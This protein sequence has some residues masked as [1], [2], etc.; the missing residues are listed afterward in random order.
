MPSYKIEIP[1]QGE[2]NVDS[3]NELSDEQVYLAVRQQL[4]QEQAVPTPPAQQTKPPQ[5]PAGILRRAGDLAISGAQGVIG[6]PESLV[7]LADIPTLG[8]AGKAAEALG[9]D[10]KRA[11]DILQ[12]YKSPEQQ[13][14]EK[15]VQ[16]AEG[17]MG[18]IGAA[19][20][21]PMAVGNTIMQSIPS[22]IGGGAIAKGILGVGAKPLSYM[23]NPATGA[24]VTTTGAGTLATALPSSAAA[25]AAG[26]GEG[27]VSGG[28]TAEQIRQGTE[29]GYLTPEQAGI[30]AV[31]GAFTGALGILGGKA[32]QRLGVGD[33]D[34]LLAGG[35]GSQEKK[36]IIVAALK[37]ALT[38]SV[39]EELPQSMQEQVAQNVATGRPWDEGVAEAGAM[40]VLAAIPMGGG[41]A[42]V[43]QWSANQR[44]D[45]IDYR[46]GLAEKPEEL[47]KQS[48]EDMQIEKN[49]IPGIKTN[50][51]GED[52]AIE[53]IPDASGASTT[54]PVQPAGGTGTTGGTTGIVGT[55][56]DGAGL[57]TGQTDGGAGAVRAPLAER[58]IDEDISAVPARNLRA[59]LKQ[60][61]GPDYTDEIDSRS[62]DGWT[63]QLKLDIAEAKSRRDNPAHIETSASPFNASELEEAGEAT[64]TTSTVSKQK[65]EQEAPKQYFTEPTRPSQDAPLGDKYKY[66]HDLMRYYVEQGES[67]V[68]LTEEAKSLLGESFDKDKDSDYITRQWGLAEGDVRTARSYT[69]D[70]QDEGESV[71]VS[72]DNAAKIAEL[73]KNREINAEDEAI[74]ERIR[75][76]VAA[77]EEERGAAMD[78]EQR[79]IV[80]KSYPYPTSSEEIPRGN[81]SAS[82]ASYD[83]DREEPIDGVEPDLPAWDN[84]TPQDR[85]LYRLVNYKEGPDAA[86]K[87]VFDHRADV[88]GKGIT[89]LKDREPQS[90]YYS[91]N[92]ENAGEQHKIKFPHWD[93][94]SP[95]AKQAFTSGSQDIEGIHDAFGKV[96]D[97]L[98]KEGVDIRGITPLEKADL[99]LRRTEEETKKVAAKENLQDRRKAG[100]ATG[101]GESVTKSDASHKAISSVQRS[102]ENGDTKSATKKLDS[103][104][105]HELNDT[106]RANV[107]DAIAKGKLDTAINLLEEAKKTE[108]QI[109]LESGDI[110]TVLSLLAEK[111][112]GIKLSV[113]ENEGMGALDAELKTPFKKLTSGMYRLVAKSLLS[114]GIDA[115]IVTDPNNS[116]IQRL[117]RIG[118]YGLYNPTTNTIYI[119]PEGMDEATI[120]HEFVHAGTVKLINKFLTNPASLTVQQREALEH[121]QK[122]FDFTKKKLGKKYVNAFKDLYEFMGYA[123]TDINFQHALR[124]IQAPTLSKYTANRVLR[125]LWNEFTT[126]LAK[127][128]GIMKAGITKLQL[129]DEYYDL[130]AKDFFANS[131]DRELYTPVAFNDLTAAEQERQL[132]AVD[133]LSKAITTA[134]EHDILESVLSAIDNDNYDINTKKDLDKLNRLISKRVDAETKARAKEKAAK[135]A[136]RTEPGQVFKQADKLL[137]AERGYAGNALLETAEIF[138]RI[139]EAPEGGIEMA[140]L[141]AAKSGAKGTKTQASQAP[142]GRTEDEMIGQAENGTPNVPETLFFKDLKSFFTIAGWRHAITKFQNDRYALVL[143]QD[144][145]KRAKRLI[146]DTGDKFNNVY[147]YV[148]EAF[149]RSMFYK[150]EYLDKPFNDLN[151]A[152]KAFM[153]AAGIKETRSAIAQ[154]GLYATAKTEHERRVPKYWK[155]VALSNTK[156]APDPTNNGQQAPAATIRRNIFLKLAEATGAIPDATIKA[157]ITALEQITGVSVQGGKI[158]IAPSQFIDPMLGHTLDENLNDVPPKKDATG[159]AIASKFVADIQVDAYRVSHLTYSEAETLLNHFEN[160]LGPE[161]KA[162]LDK[163]HPAL[164]AYQQATVDLNKMGHYWTDMVDNYKKFYNFQYYVPLKGRLNN[165]LPGENEQYSAFELSNMPL[166]TE[167]RQSVAQ[168]FEGR[169]TESQ[170]PI[171]Q[172]IVDGTTAAA[173]AGRAG[174]TQA[175]LNAV[176]DGSISAAHKPIH[177]PFKDRLH[178][179]DNMIKALRNRGTVIHYNADG[180]M[181]LITISDKDRALLEA[182]RRPF[183]ESHPVWELANRFTGFMGQQHTRFN[184]AFGLKN[185]NRD[186]LANAYIAAAEG[187]FGV[188]ARSLTGAAYNIT[189]NFSK[190][191]KMVR[192]FHQSDVAKMRAMAAADKSGYSTDLLEYIEKGRVSYASTLSVQN[193]LIT[194]HKKLGANGI[195]EAKD[196]FIKLFDAWNDTFELTARVSM[197]AAMRDAMLKELPVADRNRPSMVDGVKLHAAGYAKSMANFEEIGRYGKEMGALFMYFRASATG[198]VRAIQAMSPALRSLSSDAALVRG[199]PVTIVGTEETRNPSSK[200]FNKKHLDAY[201]HYLKDFKASQGTSAITGAA[202]LGMGATMYL[203]AAGA[204]GDDDEGRNVVISD[205]MARWTRAARFDF[206]TVNGERLTFQ[207]PWGFG[208]GGI[209]A[210]GAQVAALGMSP[211]NSA[212]DIMNNIWNISLD[213]FLPLPFSRMPVSENPSAWVVDSFTPTALRPAVEFA[214]NRNSFGQEIYNNRRTR[215]NDAYT[216]GD[217]IPEV[218][219]D[220]A[221]EL[222]QITGYDVSPNALYFWANNYMDALARV[223][224]LAGNWYLL[225]ANKKDFD[226]KHD[227]VLLDGYISNQSRVDMREYVK[228]QAEIDKLRSTLTTMREKEP[229][230]YADYLSKNPMAEVRVAAFDKMNGGALNGIKHEANLIRNMDLIPK[231]KAAMLRDNKQMQNIIMKN[232][233]DSDK[234]LKDMED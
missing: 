17:F 24:A 64:P 61:L 59:H 43:N 51:T 198:A 12:E 41:A 191:M 56:V 178:L 15:N 189:R 49:K 213:S 185:F 219:K 128:Y 55:G 125:T 144:T 7:G 46:K 215:F 233:N 151:D 130:F 208:L 38:E 234:M 132:D 70:Q 10:F 33:M 84:L 216:G 137:V 232:I 206:G 85:I 50:V 28:Q 228:T 172:T 158:S 194:T 112:R 225:A 160:K 152:I 183:Q 121:L 81:I 196:D 3:P 133:R 82:K 11:K 138:S 16:Q 174:L 68:K 145:M 188:A 166:S 163:L 97:Q 165:N 184:L 4:E 192:A 164:Q 220:A 207:L 37:G 20:E 122:V 60:L 119:T 111:A 31:S 39:F 107:E 187:H 124:G 212:M 86:R 78:A 168:G 140:P 180:S 102:L 48:A 19:A 40:G 98:E 149:P 115:T 52:N 156:T 155:Y 217:T 113:F 104:T 179:K 30:S 150:A 99:E 101:K 129:S 57:P 146:I 67:K 108:L 109:A 201:N 231:E 176:N 72:Q 69:P 93:A 230:L 106:Q 62:G 95:E 34:V 199:L 193:A 229:D 77:G 27:A 153:A 105:A 162:A 200:K 195:I 171:L 54:V 91:L 186:I 6:W 14:S 13:Q 227:T 224:Q 92:R 63:K 148:K 96:A 21:N 47:E 123:M 110:G 161:V 23:V 18:T 76:E 169:T 170:N 203:M 36:S 80:N 35:I 142:A 181:D 143:W 79:S 5:E 157:Y 103:L 65:Q 29:S 74:Q 118:Q 32:A 75:Q 218:Y 182:I 26:I 190:T 83:A 221:K 73:D 136:T 204:G 226:P 197:Y 139:L 53:P 134:E 126:S 44:K 42:G 167:L 22:M 89:P 159:N 222:F 2:F 71:S 205:D 114:V 88:E 25:I 90:I 116:E 175:I 209:P 66:L 214:M 211:A 154:M 147:D 45:L 141:P 223:P 127:L 87:A 117:Q 177:I 131:K 94:L 135:K 202:L 1:G 100:M 58:L 9:V 173:R 210:I 120:L 8:A